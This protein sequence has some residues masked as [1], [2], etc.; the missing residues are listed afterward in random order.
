MALNQELLNAVDFT[1]GNGLV[2]AIAQD[3]DTGEILMLANMN[4]ESLGM[5][6]ELGRGGL[7]EPFTRK[8]LA[9]RGRRAATFRGSGSSTVDATVTPSS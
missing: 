7:L 4:E 2:T 5:T 3:A 8:T 6:L 9:R 1:K